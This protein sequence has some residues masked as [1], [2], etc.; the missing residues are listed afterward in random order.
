MKTLNLKNRRIFHKHIWN[1]GRY[2]LR[3]GKLIILSFITLYSG[4]LPVYTQV[5][6]KMSY[7]AVVRNTTGNL[8]TNSSVSMKISILQGSATGTPVYTETHSASTNSSGLVTIEIGGGTMVNG[9]FS[10]INWANGI[11]FLKTEIDPTGGI[12][13]TISGVNQLLSVPY[14]LHAKTADN[15]ITQAQADAIVA[16]SAKNSY[17]S[18]DAA[19]LAGI[20]G[21]ETKIT[22]GTN[23][24]ITG[25]GTVANPYI[26]SA[27]GGGN[28]SARY[29]GEL[30][31]GGVIF[32]V[33]HTGLHG[34]IC[35]MVDFNTT[36]TW[37]DSPNSIIGPAAQS[38][39][40]GQG[41][42]IAIVA[43]SISVSAADS[44]DN[45]TNIDY[46]TG[47]YNDWYLPAIDELNILFNA[48][49]FVNKAIDTD[50]NGS[51]TPLIKN[52]YWSSTENAANFAWLYSFITGNPN[53]SN[54]NNKNYVRAIR[55]F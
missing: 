53:V 40:N 14:A 29:V 11:Y 10:G 13:Y 12:N 16:N 47:I 23:V 51:T 46:G 24:N 8:I 18:A 44:C 4:S 39:W 1:F 50:G 43:Q 5:P 49:R 38:D 2:L 25:K 21:S 9:S 20:D 45:Y 6:Q 41:N 33:D 22:A 54:K 3:G 31:Q 27:T 32:Y 48:R 17:P 28:G 34:L 19:K 35:S 52:N 37:S 55:A 7:Q 30:Y 15:G 26:I 36:M 42:S